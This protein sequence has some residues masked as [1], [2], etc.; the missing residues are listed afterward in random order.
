MKFFFHHC[1][2]VVNVAL[3]HVSVA[4]ENPGVS[5]LEQ[6]KAKRVMAVYNGDIIVVGVK[7]RIVAFG[8]VPLEFDF[9]VRRLRSIGHSGDTVDGVPLALRSQVLLIM[10]G[11][12]SVRTH[13]V[14]CF[15]VS[16][17]LELYRLCAIQFIPSAAVFFKLE[18]FLQVKLFLWLAA[19]HFRC[20][21]LDQ[22]GVM[23]RN[24]NICTNLTK[25][26]FVITLACKAIS[27]NARA[28]GSV[29]LLA[30]VADQSE[31]A[32]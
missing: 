10:N 25:S 2:S 14:I 19:V 30:T 8:K 11:N 15:D 21:V 24:V 22:V 27:H 12:S 20:A 26:H 6:A 28:R 17:R 29:I 4:T 18:V 23:R 32:N 16:A 9:Q 31:H 3:R 5:T 13:R 7:N 1:K